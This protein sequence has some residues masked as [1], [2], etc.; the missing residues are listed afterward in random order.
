MDNYPLH[1][2]NKFRLLKEIVP[3]KIPNTHTL[4]S[5]PALVTIN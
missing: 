5:R 3:T 4:N 1:M 2:D